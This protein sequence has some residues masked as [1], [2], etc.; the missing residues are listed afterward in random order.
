MLKLMERLNSKDYYF[1]DISF[2]MLKWDSVDLDAIFKTQRIYP[3]RSDF[4]YFEEVLELGFENGKLIRAGEY[5]EGEKYMLEILEAD[6]FISEPEESEI[7]ILFY[8][9]ENKTGS[10]HLFGDQSSYLELP[11]D[12]GKYTVNYLGK[13]SREVIDWLPFKEIE[14]FS[15]EYLK[16]VL[17][18]DYSNPNKPKYINE[19]VIE[20]VNFPFN[21]Q[22]FRIKTFRKEP[23][24]ISSNKEEFQGVYGTIGVPEWIQQPQIPRCPKTNKVMK[25]LIGIDDYYLETERDEGVISDYEPAI[26]VFMEPDTRIVGIVLQTT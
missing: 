8:L 14:L 16:G 11:V 13:I 2:E 12:Q 17:Y 20:K 4:R 5:L 25:Y 19:E 26:Y 6:E 1:S 9:L 15:P 22:A 23:V 24:E 21:D 7:R 10:N 18:I 3:N